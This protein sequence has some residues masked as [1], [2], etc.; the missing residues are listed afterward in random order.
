MII[1]IS[2]KEILKKNENLQKNNET[3]LRIFFK[4]FSTRLR[5]FCVAFHCQLVSTLLGRQRSPELWLL[6]LNLSLCLLACCFVASA[7]FH[8]PIAHRARFVVAFVRRRVSLFIFCFSTISFLSCPPPPFG[9]PP[10]KASIV[11]NSR[12]IILI[13]PKYLSLYL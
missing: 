1:W 12:S 13:F 5:N 4:K 6:S 8:N 3:I 2:T 9:P 7:A 10:H 11:T